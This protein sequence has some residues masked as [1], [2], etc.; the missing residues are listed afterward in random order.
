MKGVYYIHVMIYYKTDRAVV[1][2]NLIVLCI[3]VQVGIHSSTAHKPAVVV[4]AVEMFNNE[5]CFCKLMS[6]SIM[7]CW[8]IIKGWVDSLCLSHNVR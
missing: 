5:S 4:C 1:H 6:P 3:Q 7:Y 8:C 2:R